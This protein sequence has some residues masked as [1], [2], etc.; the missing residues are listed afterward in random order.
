MLQLPLPF[1]L[2]MEGKVEDESLGLALW[3]N[4]PE[5]FWQPCFAPFSIYLYFVFWGDSNISIQ[6]HCPSATTTFWEVK[7]FTTTSRSLEYGNGRGFTS[8]Y[9]MNHPINPSPTFF[10]TFQSQESIPSKSKS[11]LSI[12]PKQTD[13]IN[14]RCSRERREFIDFPYSV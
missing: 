12:R 4:H 2:K 3:L 10:L 9:S 7:P 1:F 14:W 11:N 6:H 13:T 5:K 8:L